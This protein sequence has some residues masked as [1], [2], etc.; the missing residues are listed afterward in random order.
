MGRIRRDDEQTLIDKVAAKL[1]S[2]KG[3]L[4]NKADRLALVNS[5]LS[6]IVLYH[7]TVLLSK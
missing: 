4:L 1:S 5:V 3:K 7:M 6:S 2:W